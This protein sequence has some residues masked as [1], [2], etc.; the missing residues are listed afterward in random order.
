ML[1]TG[2][3]WQPFMRSILTPILQIRTWWHRDFEKHL[4]PPPS[5]ERKGFPR[6]L[7]PG[8]LMI[9]HHW[10]N[11]QEFEQ[12]QGDSGKQGSLTCCSLCAR[13]QSDMN[14]PLNNN[15]IPQE[16]FKKLGC[17]FSTLGTESTMSI[18]PYFSILSRICHPRMSKHLGYDVL[19]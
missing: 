6:S 11:G 19:F 16:C 13:K 10:L 9:Q 5:L 2:R 4:K 8:C 7:T 17:D 3:C 18:W 1:E 14:E 15:M 12:T